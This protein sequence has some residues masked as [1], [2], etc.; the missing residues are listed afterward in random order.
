MGASNAKPAA[1][2]GVEC[3]DVRAIE[4]DGPTCRAVASRKHIEQRRLAGTIRADDT[5]CLSGRQRE[6]DPVEDRQ[7]SK[8]LI[9][10]GA[11]E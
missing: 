1:F 10:T 4:T 5:D 11:D 8:A 3:R 7:G 9:D 6:V 2:R